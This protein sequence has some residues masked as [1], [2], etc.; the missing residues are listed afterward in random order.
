L[1]KKTLGQF[2]KLLSIMKVKKA[3]ERAKNFL[4]A[5]MAMESLPGEAG[6]LECTAGTRLVDSKDILLQILFL[7]N[8]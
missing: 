4:L 2:L 3:F 5:P 1:K 8:L 6:S 7:I